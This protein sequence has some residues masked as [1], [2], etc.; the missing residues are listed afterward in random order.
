MGILKQ[1]VEHEAQTHGAFVVGHS[2]GEKGL[3]RFYVDS[4]DALTM[5]VL[6]DIT[7]NVSKSID[8]LDLG[9]EAFTFEVSSPGADSSLTDIRQFGKHL[10]RT[11]EM[12]TESG[13]F[14]G[15]LKSISGDQ[16]LFEENKT[17][18]INGK[19]VQQ[20]IEHQ[21]KFENIHKAIIKISF[22]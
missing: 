10:G 18:K 6:T 1:L 3:F 4:A 12:D 9:D 13:K 16:L 8:E 7:R 21:I 11:F 2:S 17:E 15:E 19:K 22:K 20:T 14:E 5:N